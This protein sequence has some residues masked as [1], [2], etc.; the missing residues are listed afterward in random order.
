MNKNQQKYHLVGVVG[1]GMSALAGALIA[2]GYQ[3][4]GS[5]RYIVTLIEEKN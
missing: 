2:A 4:S 1:T 3:V 5:D